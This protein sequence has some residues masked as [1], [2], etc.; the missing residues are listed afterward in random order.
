MLLHPEY[1]RDRSGSS[2]LV[3]LR[4]NGC[5]IAA[6]GWE[7]SGFA[8]ELI[9]GSGIQHFIMGPTVGGLDVNALTL[10][11]GE[12]QGGVPDP[13]ATMNTERGIM[14]RHVH[15]GIT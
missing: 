1:L 4:N 13:I 7:P 3:T 8:R 14:V 2:L 12:M 6:Y 10:L 15:I 5:R 9:E 11:I